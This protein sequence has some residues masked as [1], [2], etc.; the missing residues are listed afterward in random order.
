MSGEPPEVIYAQ[1]QALHPKDSAPIQLNA[2]EFS[3][4]ISEFQYITGKLIGKL[5][6]RAKRGTAVDQWGWDSRE[7][8][9]DILTDTAFL[10]IVAKHW[11]LPVAAG[12][13]PAFYRQHLAGGR[14]V[15]LSKSPKLGV[16]PINIT[17]AWRRVAA[18]ALLSSCLPDFNTFF[19]QGHPRVFQFATATADGATTMFHLINAIWASTSQAQ[20]NSDDAFIILTLDLKNAYN[21]KSRQRIYDFFAKSCPTSDHQHTGWNILWQHFVAHYGLTGLLK[22]YHSGGTYTIHSETGTQQDDPLGGLLFAAPLHPICSTPRQHIPR[23]SH[24]CLCRQYS[25]YGPKFSNT[26]SS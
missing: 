7:M 21:A 15:A 25:I 9:R 8:W 1:L 3:V 20:T 10:D 13:L 24:L 23:T 2:P 19:Q 4:P 17:D 16:R 22:F 6:R 14:L 18:K 11:I 5:L 26:P 12:Y